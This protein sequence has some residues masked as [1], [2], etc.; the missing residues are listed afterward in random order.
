MRFFCPKFELGPFAN[1]GNV[2][3]DRELQEEVTE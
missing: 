1:M 2:S 3:Q